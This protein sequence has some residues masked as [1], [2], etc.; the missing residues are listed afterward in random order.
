MGLILTFIRLDFY[1]AAV[2]TTVNPARTRLTTVN[3]YATLTQM[4]ARTIKQKS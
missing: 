2:F 3:I 1:R 4:I